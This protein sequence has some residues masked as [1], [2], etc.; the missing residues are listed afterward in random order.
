MISHLRPWRRRWWQLERHCQWTMGSVMNVE[1]GS[2]P[3]FNASTRAQRYTTVCVPYLCHELPVLWKLF[4]SLLL[5][6]LFSFGPV[7]VC[8]LSQLGLLLLNVMLS[9]FFSITFPFI[10]AGLLHRRLQVPRYLAGLHHG[11][12]WVN[13]LHRSTVKLTEKIQHTCKMHLLLQVLTAD[14]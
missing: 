11:R 4:Y 1:E 9:F 2:G 10:W 8:Q 14:S 6:N 5:I 7:A 3:L 13:N 12:H